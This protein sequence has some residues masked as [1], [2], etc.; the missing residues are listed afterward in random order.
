MMLQFKNF[1]N[2]RVSEK[3]FLILFV[4]LFVFINLNFVS[5]EYFRVKCTSG[6]GSPSIRFGYTDGATENADGNYDALYPPSPVTPRIDF[7]L[8]N[9]GNNYMV[10]AR[11]G[12]SITDF[13]ARI[14]GVSITGIT[15]ADLSFSLYDNGQGNFDG[16]DF[17]VKLY[18]ASD[19]TNP[20]NLIA[21]YDIYDL[22]DGYES[23]PE[24]N[25]T[26][27]LSY[28]LVIDA[29]YTPAEA[30]PSY[31][32]GSSGGTEETSANINN[33]VIT[34]KILNIPIIINKV[35]KEKIEL[36]NNGSSII[37]IS[38][39]VEGLEDIL[40]IKKKDKSFNL[41]AGE[42]KEIE[43]KIAAPAEPGIYTGK[44]I[45]NGKEVLVTLNVNTKELLFDA[46]IMI[47]DE[48]KIINKGDKLKTKITLIP[49]GEAGLDVTLEYMI[50]DFSGKIFLSESET[51]KVNENLTFTKEFATNNLPVGDYIL[52]LEVIYE[53]KV[54]T[55]SVNFKVIEKGLLT[56]SGNSILLILGI[57]VIIL[58]LLILIRYK[59][60]KHR[61]IKKHRRHKR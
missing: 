12:D 41:N 45:I 36:Y 43:I 48:L 31:G 42:R 26:T 46:K 40:I 7:Y 30:G 53:E 20:T 34:P 11:G 22:I 52:G 8:Q 19:Y 28:Q 1:D 39:D 4:F 3:I 18:N 44:I 55:T 61:N 17:A 32:G 54:A 21:A 60:I 33:L 15:N 13:Y 10:D 57:A 35:A 2:K 24:L 6:I 14:D 25:I 49:L 9:S 56:L 5:A 37:N 51:I 59:S 27:G 50:S 47:P 23:F 16:K 58:I 38:I 29:S